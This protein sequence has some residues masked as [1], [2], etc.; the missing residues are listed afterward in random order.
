MYETA[1]NNDLE[2][3]NNECPLHSEEKVSFADGHIEILDVVRTPLFTANRKLRGI[4]G[5]ARDVSQRV[6]VEK[7]LRQTQR[8]LIGAVDE[9]NKASASKSEFLAR[10][11]HE[12]R[13][14]MNAI[15]GMTN[16]TK[17]KLTEGS[18]SDDLMPHIS[19]IEASS[20]HLLGLLNDILDISKIEAGKIELSEESFSLTQLINDV[21]NIIRPRC[22]SKKISFNVAQDSLPCDA[23]IS[24]SLRLRQIII[25]L[26]G[27]AVKF[28]PEFGSIDFIIQIRK[29]KNDRDYIY[30]S[31]KDT[32]IGISQEH[33]QNLF[34]PFEQGGSHITRK[35]GGTGL[36]LSI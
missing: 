8:N 34:N 6:A 5:V 29:S 31:V 23:Y 32:G 26:L 30:F 36:G 22:D 20:M 19:Q 9:A 28:T 12:I 25:N 11:S 2:A 35:F 13:T 14:P 33:L 17:R 21:A 10:M 1:R 16:I 3:I 24:D 27:N 18:V 4:L 15:I 7:E